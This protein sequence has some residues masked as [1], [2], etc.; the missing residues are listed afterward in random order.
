MTKTSQASDAVYIDG[1]GLHENMPAGLIDRPN[2][3]DGWL[4]MHFYDSVTLLDESGVHQHPAGRFILWRPGDKQYYGNTEQEWT[5][6]WIHLCGNGIT[7]QQAHN[8]IPENQ[9]LALSYPESLEHS[10]TAIY[11]ELEGPFV[12]NDIIISN[13]VENLFRQMYR[14]LMEKPLFPRIPENIRK[15]KRYIELNFDKPFSLKDLSGLGNLSETY[16][17]GQ[18]SRFFGYPP[19]EYRTRVRLNH[20]TQLL[21]DHNL[22]ISEIA[23]RIG[24]SDVYH[25]SKQF[26]QHLG[27]SPGKFRQQMSVKSSQP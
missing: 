13:L 3:T 6:S 8:P 17:C 20:A 27:I 12:P 21:R 15:V 4:F 19:I 23:Q 26:K 7:G 5:H 25:F 16:L 11:D 18:F 9:A 14:A 22:R 2:G 10:L 24:Y 1:I